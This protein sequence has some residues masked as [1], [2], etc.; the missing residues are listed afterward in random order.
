[1]VQNL[2][3]KIQYDSSIRPFVNG[4]VILLSSNNLL[5]ISLERDELI[6]SAIRFARSEDFGGDDWEET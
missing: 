6:S 3:M 2:L 5:P 4:L 1:M